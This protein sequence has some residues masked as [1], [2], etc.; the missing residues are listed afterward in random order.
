M[1]PLARRVLVA[2]AVG[3]LVVSIAAS[4]LSL[5]SLI[6]ARQ[7]AIEAIDDARAALSGL[8]EYRIEALVP[9]NTTFPVSV[10]VPLS[11]EFV[12]P[13]RTTIPITT[14]STDTPTG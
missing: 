3:A 6:R 11:Q 8:S 14:T 10:E 12:V 5:Y 9:I 13:I 2:V 4:I 1:T 7:T